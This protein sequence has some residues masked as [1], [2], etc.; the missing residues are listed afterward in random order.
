M[1]DFQSGSDGGE[2]K[3]QLMF[4]VN[5]EYEMPASVDA[6]AVERLPA[7][8]VEMVEKIHATTST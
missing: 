6:T 4:L 7:I 8:R 5:R 3:A 2:A 1:N